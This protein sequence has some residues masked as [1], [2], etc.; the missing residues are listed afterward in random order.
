MMAAVRILIWLQVR[1]VRRSS[2]SNMTFSPWRL[3]FAWR[4]SRLHPA[5]V[6]N[7]TPPPWRT[8]AQGDAGRICAMVYRA[9]AV[10]SFRTRSRRCQ[11]ASPATGPG[12]RS[13]LGQG[14][15]GGD[16]AWFI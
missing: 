7:V 1:L 13:R 12:G 3:F 6:R 15:E 9:D 16:G 8:E 11:T 4:A 5:G 10:G 14:S 2:I